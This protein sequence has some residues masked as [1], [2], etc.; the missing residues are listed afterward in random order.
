MMTRKRLAME[1]VLFA[2]AIYIGYFAFMM[3]QGMV[4]TKRH[5]QDLDLAK[6]YERM[7]T[8]QPQVTFGMMERSSGWQTAAAIGGFVLLG[9]LY[10]CIRWQWTKRRS[11]S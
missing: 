6:Q 3:L 2:A 5:A 8:L 4:L 9:G 1:S 7:E 10:G 11:Q